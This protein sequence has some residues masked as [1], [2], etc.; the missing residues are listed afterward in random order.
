MKQSYGSMFWVFDVIW[1]INIPIDFLVIRYTIVSRDSLDIA[2]DY[3]K[4]EF[5]F[6]LVATFPSLITHHS[7]KT[8]PLRLLH[9]F[10]LR[11]LDYLL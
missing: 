6:D 5:L 7:Q 2:L 4:S 8:M 10:H 3:I 11:K 9:I 1:M